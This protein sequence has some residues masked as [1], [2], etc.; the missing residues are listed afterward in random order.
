MNIGNWSSYQEKPRE[1]SYN[2]IEWHVCGCHEVK[3][4]KQTYMHTS[5]S[6]YLDCEGNSIV[7][8]AESQHIYTV[9]RARKLNGGGENGM[10]ATTA[11]ATKTAWLPWTFRTMH[12]KQQTETKMSLNQREKG[13]KVK[14]DIQRGRVPVVNYRPFHSSAVCKQA[15]LFR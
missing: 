12:T 1:N 4:H 11:R 10:K 6:I 8:K 14:S 5:I 2:T 3:M 7:R 15:K 13:C 9:R